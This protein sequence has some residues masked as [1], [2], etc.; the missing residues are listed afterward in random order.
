MDA[1]R[2]DCLI[3]LLALCAGISVVIFDYLGIY[4][5]ATILYILIIL[6]GAAAILYLVFFWII[7]LPNKKPKIYYSVEA[8]DTANV[9]ISCSRYEFGK[10][11]HID[12]DESI[13]IKM[14]KGQRITV[15]V[16][17]G[18]R[19]FSVYRH[20]NMKTKKDFCIKEDTSLH[21]WSETS[22]NKTPFH[23]EV[24]SRD[25][26][27]HDELSREAYISS[28]SILLLVMLIY[29]VIALGGDITILH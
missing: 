15:K 19:S 16:P 18:N 6:I 12:I 10:S 21:V 5:F 4:R 2:E 26:E 7:L 17:C 22:T 27:H 1:K 3:I 29:L 23:I 11:I 13:Q 14:Y 9:S 8:T 25:D 24:S 28:I 20:E